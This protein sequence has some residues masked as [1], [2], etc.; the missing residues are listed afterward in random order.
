MDH[1]VYL[2]VRSHK[3]VTLIDM[4]VL[5][6]LHFTLISGCGCR[7]RSKCFIVEWGCNTCLTEPFEWRVTWHILLFLILNT[8]FVCSSF[9]M[10]SHFVSCGGH[11]DQEDRAR[12]VCTWIWLCVIWN[13]THWTANLRVTHLTISWIWTWKY[14][15]LYGDV[16]TQNEACLS[17]LLEGGLTCAVSPGTQ[18]RNE[19]KLGW[20]LTTQ[21][22]HG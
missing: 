3:N 22:R 6:G 8:G 9:T 4:F 20:L 21:L 11:K 19:K 14:L 7:E 15:R 5:C 18:V 10:F 16:I 12:V 1:P 2:V 13:C 17:D